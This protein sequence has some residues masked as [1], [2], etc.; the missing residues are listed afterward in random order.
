MEKDK[1]MLVDGMA[2]LFRAFYATAMSGYYMI[3]S[4]GMPTNAV[5]GFVKHLFTATKKYDPSHVICCWDMGSRTFRTEI[6]PEYK[7]NRGEP[8]VELVPQ[9]DLVKEVVEALDIPNV[10]LAG[11]EADDC[12]GTLSKEYSKHSEVIILTGDQD[13]LQLLKENVT[14][15]LLK[16]GY[17]NYA[18]YQMDTFYEEKGITP[19]Q[20]IDLKALMGD[21]S[22][23][24]PGVKGIGEKTALKLL[25]TYGSIEGILE[26]LSSLTKGQ[27]T[28]IE[29][30][31]DM[32]H[33]SR[34]LAE[35]NCEVGVDCSLEEAAYQINQEMMIKKFKELE[36]KRLD[37]LI[38]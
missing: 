21:S 27:R 30:D 37:S 4:K 33:L 22:D 6:F 34:K 29:S 13:I 5:Y 36:F 1:V 2:L 10:G 9:F 19:K 32:L 16:K 31:L 8:P 23:N 24:Y 35:I 26:N 17:G 28:K 12:I 7:A 14:V 18:E 38:S 15:S 25:S 11:F 3:N 20:M